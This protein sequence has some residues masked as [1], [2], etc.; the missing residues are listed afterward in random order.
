[1]RNRWRVA[2][3]RWA[4]AVLVAGLGL[5]GSASATFISLGNGTIRDTTTNLVWEQNANHGPFNWAGANTYANT[6]ALAGGGWHLATITELQG[7]YNDLQIA[8]VCTGANC[9]GNI[10][11]FTGIQPFYWSGTEVIPGTFA[12]LF[13]FDSGVQGAGGEGSQLSAWAVRSGNVAAVPEPQTVALLLFGLGLLG[14]RTR[15]FCHV[16]GGRGG[17][18]PPVSENFT[19]Y[20]AL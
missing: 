9:T 19:L 18:P 4:T 13:F 1:M 11:G 3:K 5:A 17:P 12:R 2:A 20:G 10:A 8:S 16:G 14:W 6:L 15:V 7:L